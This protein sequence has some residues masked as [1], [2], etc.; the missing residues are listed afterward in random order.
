MRRDLD[1]AGVEKIENGAEAAAGCERFSRVMLT[2]I[3]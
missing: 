1:F 2:H 3:T